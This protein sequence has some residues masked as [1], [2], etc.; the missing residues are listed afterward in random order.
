IQA[1]VVRFAN[2]LDLATRTMLTEIDLDNAQH[3]LYPRMYTTVMLDLVR[4]PD[5]IQLPASAVDGIGAKSGFVYVVDGDALT[6]RPVS[7]G[8]TDGRLVEITSGLTGNE[9]VVATISPAFSAGE[10]I[11]PVWLTARASDPASVLASDR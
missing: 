5:A 1:R 10:R 7:L 8:I 6:K 11:K 2:S 4:H 3:K 9:S